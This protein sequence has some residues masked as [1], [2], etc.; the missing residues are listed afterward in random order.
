M[1]TKQRMLRIK[2]SLKF[3]AYNFLLDLLLARYSQLGFV[4]RKVA[5]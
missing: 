2:C 5:S 1:V 3:V 4:D